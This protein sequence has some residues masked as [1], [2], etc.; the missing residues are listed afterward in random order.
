MAKVWSAEWDSS[1]IIIII[2]SMW[3]SV[4][5]IIIIITQMSLATEL[6]FITWLHLQIDSI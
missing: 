2:I 5:I 1:I 3:V 6:L 4:I